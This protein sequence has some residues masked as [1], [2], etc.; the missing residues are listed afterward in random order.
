MS[1]HKVNDTSPFEVL[2]FIFFLHR[3][4][5]ALLQSLPSA[6]TVKQGHFTFQ[7]AS[8]LLQ[9]VIKQSNASVDNCTVSIIMDYIYFK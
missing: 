3:G 5:K 7:N 8:Q 2:G 4:K 9:V 1:L 6:R